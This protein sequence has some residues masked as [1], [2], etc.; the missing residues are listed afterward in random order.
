MVLSER[1]MLNNILKVWDN[2]IKAGYTLSAT[3]FAFY[4][5]HIAQT[6]IEVIVSVRIYL[7]CESFA[8]D[9]LDSS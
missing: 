2:L 5:T 6:K 8:H 9:I 1:L 7:F 3:L 4:I